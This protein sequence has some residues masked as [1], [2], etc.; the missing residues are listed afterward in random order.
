MGELT[1]KNIA[2][3]LLGIT[4]TYP[5]LTVKEGTVEAWYMNCHDIPAEVFGVA[6]KIALQE[7]KYS[8]LPPI[9]KIREIAINLMCGK[10][11]TYGQAFERVMAEVRKSGAYKS[12]EA[13]DKLEQ[14]IPCIREIINQLGGFSALCQSNNIDVL[15][16]HFQRLWE[17]MTKDIVR[18]S[19]LVGSQRAVHTALTGQTSLRKHNVIEGDTE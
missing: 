6:A 10:L 16:A 9:G 5:T 13:L 1:R 12:K 18:Q 17:A 3:V 19:C 15:R 8:G 7:D 11:P 2:K 4:A 14:E